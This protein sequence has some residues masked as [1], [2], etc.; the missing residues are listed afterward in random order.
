MAAPRSFSYL[1]LIFPLSEFPRG[2]FTRPSRRIKAHP[3]RRAAFSSF[4]PPPPIHY[5]CSPTEQNKSKNHPLFSCAYKRHFHQPFSFVMVT[6]TGGCVFL[7]LFALSRA[8]PFRDTQ[9]RPQLLFIQ[10]FTSQFPGY[11]GW[12][13]AVPRQAFTSLALLTTHNSLLTNSLQYPRPPFVYS[14]GWTSR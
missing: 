4:P 13:S 14:I 6:N 1:R 5:S 12:G 11:W 2:T 10:A 8:S 9:Q 3:G 7:K